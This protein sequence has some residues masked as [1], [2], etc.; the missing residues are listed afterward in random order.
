MT[1]HRFVRLREV[2]A[3]TGLARSTIY[4]RIQQGRFPKPIPLGSSHV[5]GFLVEEIEAWISEQVRAARPDDSA[6]T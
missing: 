1:A 2:Q 4:L 6:A 5:V 3:R